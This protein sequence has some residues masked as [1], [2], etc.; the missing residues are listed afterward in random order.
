[1]N[2]ADIWHI[3][4]GFKLSFHE[5]A[6]KPLTDYKFSES[7]AIIPIVG[8]TSKF[9]GGGT[10]STLELREQIRKVANDSL[11]EQVLLYFDTPGGQVSG[12]LDFAKDVADLS[13]AKPTFSFAADLL[14][15]A[16]YEVA[17][18]T[19]KIIGNDSSFI[20]SIGTMSVL[21]D[22]SEMF[23]RMGVKAIPLTSG[24]M[25]GAGMDGVPITEE[26]IQY[27]QG[28][29]DSMN[30]QFIEAVA[31]GRNMDADR[32]RELADGR[33]H[34][35]ADAAR[36]GL[37]DEIGSLDEAIEGLVKFS[38]QQRHFSMYASN[39]SGNPAG[40]ALPVS[41][42]AL[43]PVS[44]VTPQGQPALQPAAVATPALPAL[45]PTVQDPVAPTVV[46]AVPTVPT[47]TPADPRQFAT[48]EDIEAACPHA[49]ADFILAQ[50]KA[51]A[52]VQQAQTAFIGLMASEVLQLRSAQQVAPVALPPAIQQ[53]PQLVAQ[54]A[55]QAPAMPGNDP[56]L[57][58]PNQSTWPG[59]AHSYWMMQVEQERDSL[60]AAGY[61]AHEAQKQA[62]FGVNARYPGL[63]D[64]AYA[65]TNAKGPVYAPK[66]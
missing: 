33:L 18:Q 21:H 51:K 63:R 28:L 1:M 53:A 55:L 15:S 54:P 52:T 64:E 37:I 31:K 16:G 39:G 65:E 62:V 49:P 56:V 13:A 41:R 20:G 61:N 43:M 2:T 58:D 57:Q 11:A 40:V 30:D 23:S 27:S 9:G 29:I 14:A 46:A 10:M 38:P 59:N 36:L 6:A 24:G 66:R 17:S 44:E 26:T 19:G 25:K 4:E 35:A 48:I 32:V 47:A 5:E 50:V 7:T 45:S 22:T 8:P 3:I 42:P 34:I 12:N 60:K